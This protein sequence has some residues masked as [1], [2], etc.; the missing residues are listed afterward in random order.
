M[1]LRLLRQ[2]IF[3]LLVVCYFEFTQSSIFEQTNKI[4]ISSL[5]IWLFA[6][7]LAF[8]CLLLLFRFVVSLIKKD[9]LIS[10]HDFLGDKESIE[11]IN[12]TQKEKIVLSRNQFDE[13]AIL[14]VKAMSAITSGLMND[15]RRHLVNLRKIIGD[16]AII[17]ILMLKIYK[18]EKNFDKI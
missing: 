11:I 8:E 7:Y 12:S 2:A 9:V 6:V 15:A 14:I 5:A 10:N 17:D 4:D 16:D 13:A 1:I 3:L 18:G